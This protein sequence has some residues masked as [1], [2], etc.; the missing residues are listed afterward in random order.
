MLFTEEH[1]EAVLA[2]E[3]TETRRQ[4]DEPQVKEG[5]SYRATTDLFT[6][7][8]EAPAYVVVTSLYQQRL[9]DIT[10][11]AADAEGGYT[12]SEFVAEWREINGEWNPEE[13]VWVVEFEG[14]ETDPRNDE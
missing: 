1:I 2:G 7:R 10:P 9:G 14:V 13:T 11:A 8:D 5:N 12:V 6:P 3:K 4:W